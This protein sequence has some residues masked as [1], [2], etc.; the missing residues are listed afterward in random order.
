MAVMW[1]GQL[2][3]IMKDFLVLGVSFF[4][5]LN[6]SFLLLPGLLSTLLTPSLLIAIITQFHRLLEDREYFVMLT[7]GISPWALLRPILFLVFWVTILQAA[8]SFYISPYALQILRFERDHYERQFIG[9]AIAPQVFRDIIPNLTTYAKSAG[10]DGRVN[11]VMIYDDRNP[12]SPTIYIAEQGQIT[13]ANDDALLILYNGRILQQNADHRPTNRSVPFI[14]F[15]EYRLPI[16]RNQQAPL[17]LA[18]LHVRQL[19]LHHLIAPEKIG[20]TREKNLTKIRRFLYEL[21]G[22]L[23]MPLIFALIALGVMAG[24]ELKRRGYGR[25][26]F[27]AIILGV[28]YYLIS[29]LIAGRAASAVAYLPLLLIWPISVL[30][31][32]SLFLLWR[33]EPQLRLRQR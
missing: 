26:I 28:I 4:A 29:T 27:T 14:A 12:R 31:G 16:I 32:I 19:L 10:E 33:Y 6:L 5:I 20:V 25:Q 3:S 13:R 18:D 23:A 15:E 30:L 21:I 1:L 9:N 24:G 2:L 11:D 8:L 17:D 22:N 7:A